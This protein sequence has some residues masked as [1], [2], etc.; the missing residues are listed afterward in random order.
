M[1]NIVKYLC[2]AI[3]MLPFAG[4]NPYETWPDGLAELEHVY[5]VS[6]V[7]TGNGTELDLQ[8]E[9]AAD[10]TAKFV[11]RIHYNPNNTPA[12]QYEWVTSTESNVTMPM[13]IRFISEKVR[14]YDV[15]TYFWVENR[16][17]AALPNTPAVNA[18]WPNA[19]VSPVADPPSLIEGRDYVVLTGSGATMTP[20]A[21]GV[22]S[23]TWPQAI[24]GQQSVKI[25]RLSTATGQLRLVFLDRSKI[26]F[27]ANDIPNRDDLEVSLLNNK[28]SDYTIRGLWHDYRY[29]V[30]VNF[31]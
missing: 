17:L 18:A 13:D 19:A 26:T 9:I 3:V 31:R 30:I 24:K 6:N 21:Q 1:K 15:V 20:N 7:K 2:A 16:N 29:P 8:H 12:P 27:T 5:Y 14:T 25:K 11:K 23:L 10:G 4:C 28:T 22:Y